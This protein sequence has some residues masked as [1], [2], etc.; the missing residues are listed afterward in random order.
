MGALAATTTPEGELVGYNVSFAREI[1]ARLGLDVELQQPLFE[2]VID[3]VAGHECDISVSSQNI[4][5]SRLARISMIPYTKSH[6]PILVAV[7]NPR[8]IDSLQALCGLAVSATAGTTHVDLIRGAGDYADAS[9]NDDCREAARDPIDL[10]LFETDDAAFNALLEGDVVAYLGNT[11]FIVDHDD[12]VD[13]AQISMPQARQGIGVAID[14]PALF[15]AV[16]SALN[17]MIA[18]G[19]YRRILAEHLPDASS[20]DFV[21][22]EE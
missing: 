4:T 17:T 19:T 11:G 14:H 7:G 20:V 15:A 16:D 2:D 10:K 12:F 13:Y 8:H 21:S 22:I 18:D 3:L 6:Q 5:A 1:G 9:L